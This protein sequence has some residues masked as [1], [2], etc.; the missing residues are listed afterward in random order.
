MPETPVNSLDT[1]DDLIDIAN[2]TGLG[3]TT[4]PRREHL[5]VEGDEE[6]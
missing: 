5:P 1:L 3:Q 2:G 6:C 4:W